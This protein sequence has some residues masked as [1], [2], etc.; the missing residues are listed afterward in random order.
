M[1][2]QIEC[3]G[4]FCSRLFQKSNVNVDIEIVNSR[5]LESGYFLGDSRLLVPKNCREWGSRL[6]L[7]G[8]KYE[9]Q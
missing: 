5:D 4:T 8:K 3:V 2:R 9:N 7:P 1:L 6:R